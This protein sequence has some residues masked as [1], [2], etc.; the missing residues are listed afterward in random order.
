MPII[1]KTPTEWRKTQEKL[2]HTIGFVPTMGNLHAGHLALVERAL[3][4]NETV[5]VSIFVNHTQF[6]DP[7]D[8][9]N[10][11]RTL[12]EDCS[13]LDA[14]NAHYVFNPNKDTMYPENYEV[15]VSENT[16]SEF[17]EG[18]FRQ[19]HFTGM[20]T[21]VLKLLNI[22]GADKAYFGEK[23]FQQLKL[24]QK[25]VNA[26]FIPTEIIACPTMREENGLALSSRNN[27]L[28]DDEKNHAS[29][30]YKYL[31]DFNLSDLEVKEALEKTGFRPEYVETKW[32]RRL[33]AAWLGDVRLIDNIPIQERK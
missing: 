5:V 9:D 19:G 26:L 25:M 27:R 4:E 20:L 11:L 21:V 32:G 17:M 7:A 3:K 33:T 28:T 30:L 14:I 6:N 24:I 2:N 16:D 10:Y 18:Q 23:D 31:S 29:L 12:D 1:I 8:Y 22:I 15:Q 13:K